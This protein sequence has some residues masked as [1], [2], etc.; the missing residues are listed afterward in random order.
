MEQ[1]HKSPHQS[2][3]RT[4]N[5]RCVVARGKFEN[6]T[7]EIAALWLEHLHL[8]RGRCAWRQFGKTPS[9]ISIHQ[10]HFSKTLTSEAKLNSFFPDCFFPGLFILSLSSEKTCCYLILAQLTRVFKASCKGFWPSMCSSA[11][12]VAA[13]VL[14]V[15][16]EWGGNGVWHVDSGLNPLGLFRKAAIRV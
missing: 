16:T 13:W 3:C 9:W 14:R 5:G 12:A 15:C 2:R 4:H 10:R 7:S 6:K 11:E 8:R 1:Q